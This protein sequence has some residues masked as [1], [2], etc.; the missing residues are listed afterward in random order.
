MLFITVKIRVFTLTLLLKL[1]KS[2][3]FYPSVITPFFTHFERKT[4][5]LLRGIKSQIP[6]FSLEIEILEIWNL[7]F[8]S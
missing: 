6:N 5:L 4:A 3:I 7:K 1:N 2:E 8:L